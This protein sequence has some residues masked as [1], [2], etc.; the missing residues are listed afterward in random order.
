VKKESVYFRN[1]VVLFFVFLRQC[2]NVLV[3]AAD[4]TQGGIIAQK[5]VVW[6]NKGSVSSSA[7]G[8]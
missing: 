1:V 5:W 2:R 7:W 8:K 4:I 6:R 3:N